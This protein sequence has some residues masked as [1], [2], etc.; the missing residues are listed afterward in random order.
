[1][2]L[3]DLLPLVEEEKS[4]LRSKHRRQQGLVSLHGFEKLSNIKLPAQHFVSFIDKTVP[5]PCCGFQAH[6]LSIAAAHNTL[7]GEGFVKG[8]RKAL[9]AEDGIY[10]RSYVCHV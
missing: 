9:A 3:D 1:M 2:Q 10:H 7:L 8:I 5:L 6:F 4:L